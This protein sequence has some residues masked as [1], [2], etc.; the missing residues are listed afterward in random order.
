MNVLFDDGIYFDRRLRFEDKDPNLA[1]DYWGR[2]EPNSEAFRFFSPI[3]NIWGDFY[4]RDMEEKKYEFSKLSKKKKYERKIGLKER[5]YLKRIINPKRFN[6]T[7][8]IDWEKGTIG[9]I[10]DL[11]QLFPPSENIFE[12]NSV[13]GVAFNIYERKE[14]NSLKHKNRNITLYYYL[15]VRLIVKDIVSF[16]R[17]KYP[18]TTSNVDVVDINALLAEIWEPRKDL[19]PPNYDSEFLNNVSPTL[20]LN[21]DT[22]INNRNYKGKD[23]IDPPL[24]W[25]NMPFEN[26]IHWN[27]FGGDKFFIPEKYWGFNTKSNPKRMVVRIGRK[28]N[29]FYLFLHGDQEA[30]CPIRIPTE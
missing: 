30:G 14:F 20:V 29:R 27:D 26:P 6:G 16:N 17:E 4:A 10:V 13:I 19:S 15:D 23:W 24:H 21:K 8:K 25:K 22:I 12:D 1:N 9:P 28:N 5:Y 3:D 7:V 11:V 18:I 2:Y